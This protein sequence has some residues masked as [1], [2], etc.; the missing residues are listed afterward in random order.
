MNSCNSHLKCHLSKDCLTT[1]SI[2]ESSITQY[3]FYHNLLLFTGVITSSHFKVNWTYKLCMYLLLLD[4]G[5]YFIHHAHP[6]PYSLEQHLAHKST[7]KSGG[8]MR[9]WMKY[10]S[11]NEK[12]KHCRKR[13]HHKACQNRDERYKRED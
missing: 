6:V 2:R 5:I 12:E 10:S 11:N 9:E 8:W 3:P 4:G 1:S 13:K 7:E